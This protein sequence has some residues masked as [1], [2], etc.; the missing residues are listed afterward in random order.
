MTYAPKVENWDDKAKKF[1]KK[2]RTAF[3]HHAKEVRKNERLNQSQPFSPVNNGSGGQVARII[4]R[5]SQGSST[6][7]SDNTSK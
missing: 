7:S 1:T 5:P 2:L 6:N 4:N 3:D